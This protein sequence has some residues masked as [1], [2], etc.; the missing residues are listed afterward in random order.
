MSVKYAVTPTAAN[1]LLF[2]FFFLLDFQKAAWVRLDLPCSSATLGMGICQDCLSRVGSAQSLDT[3]L[4][5]CEILFF[6]SPFC[7]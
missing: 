2:F 3:P 5:G 7:A 1:L 4:A 6:L